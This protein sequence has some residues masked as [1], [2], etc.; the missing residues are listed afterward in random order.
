MKINI[1]KLYLL[2]KFSKKI[3]LISG[4][5]LVL[6]LIINLIEEA[7]FLKNTESD[8]LLPIL[9]SLLN[10]PSLIYEMFPFIFLISTQFFFIDLI[11]SKELYTFKHFRLDNL[12]IIKFLSLVSFV[13]GV[14]IVILFYN[15][16]SVLKNQYLQ[17][18]NKYTN[19]NKYLAVITENGL[20]IRDIIES[21][22]IIVNAD[23]IDGNLLLNSSITEFN[24]NFEIERNFIT[25]KIDVTNNEWILHNGSVSKKDNSSINFQ[26]TTFLS[27]FNIQKINSLFSDLTSLSFLELLKLKKDYTSIGYSTDEIDI[28]THKLYSLPFL[29]LIMTIISTLIMMNIKYQKK[30]LFNLFIGIFLSVVIYY[31][32]HF[33]S[34][35][36]IN[37]K[38]PLILSVWLPILVLALISIIGMVRI[39]EK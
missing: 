5:F 21:K 27:N 3:V 11:E 39:N 6:V 19:D 23:K 18:K 31:I 20:W 34:L 12:K 28:Q 33:S 17:I 26:K 22:V 16:S 14:L 24:S 29:L 32:G 10:A 13:F 9:L 30:I 36:G 8:F 4:I 37:K 25:E 15:F 35:L 1:Y 7:N 2:K 38:I